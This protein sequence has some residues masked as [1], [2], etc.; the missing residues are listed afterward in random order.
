MSWFANFAC[1]RYSIRYRIEHFRPKQV[2][3]SGC[4]MQLRAHKYEVR[5]SY[6]QRGPTSAANAHSCL[7]RCKSVCLRKA[8]H[9]YAPFRQSTSSSVGWHLLV[10]DIVIR[11][12]DFQK[13]SRKCEVVNP[14]SSNIVGRVAYPARND[15]TVGVVRLNLWL[16]PIQERLC[17]GR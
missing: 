11:M 12:A 1:G 2:T 7:I 16:I 10:D 4:S 6:H 13:V 9:V 8:D 14:K 3:R 15:Q 5:W 17:L